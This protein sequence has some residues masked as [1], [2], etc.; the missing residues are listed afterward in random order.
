[1][2]I[3]LLKRFDEEE[4]ERQIRKCDL[5]Y[6][7][8]AEEF[9]LEPLKTIEEFGKKVIDNSMLYYYTEDKWMFY[10]KCKENKIPTPDTILLSNNLNMARAALRRFGKWPVVLKRI[11]GTCGIH[12]KRAKNMEEAL[13]IIKDFWKRDLDKIPI[14]AQE[15]V[16][17]Y[18]YRATIIDNKVV[19]TAVKKSNTWKCTGLYAKSCEQ[20]RIDDQLRKIL[21]RTIKVMKINICGVD[22]LKSDRGWLVLEV[23]SSPGLDFI[24]GE[25]EMLV[26]KILDFV[27]KFYRERVV[28][29]RK[30]KHHYT[31]L[32]HLF[33]S[34]E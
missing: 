1:M 33:H 24:E 10:I 34:F 17:S 9:V 11:Y 4:F 21:N 14:I 31:G 25:R 32:K 30:Y 3:N 22:L 15:Y 18:S 8:S 13:K 12:V 23:N 19:Q 7:N 20:F 27:K 2:M 28:N 29:K 26:S 5:I 6:N 16:K